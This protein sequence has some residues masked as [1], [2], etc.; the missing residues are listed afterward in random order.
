MFVAAGIRNVP[1]REQDQAASLFHRPTHNPRLSH[2]AIVKPVLEA[3]S[4]TD[5]LQICFHPSSHPRHIISQGFHAP[6]YQPPRQP[7]SIAQAFK[8][9]H[10]KVSGLMEKYSGRVK[11]A[12]RAEVRPSQGREKQKPVRPRRSGDCSE[13]PFEIFHRSDMVEHG[14]N[15]AN[16]TERNNWEESLSEPSHEARQQRM[17]RMGQKSIQTYRDGSE[18]PSQ[19]LTRGSTHSPDVINHYR[20]KPLPQLPSPRQSNDSPVPNLKLDALPSEPR[21]GAAD[22]ELY[23]MPEGRQRLTQQWLDPLDLGASTLDLTV[24]NA[25]SGGASPAASPEPGMWF[26]QR[27][28]PGSNIRTVNGTVARHHSFAQRPKGP[29][30]VL[31]TPNIPERRSSLAHRDAHTMPRIIERHD[32]L[33]QRRREAKNI[34]IFPSD[35][36]DSFVQRGIH[37]LRSMTA[38]PS[39]SKSGVREISTAIPEGHVTQERNSHGGA[40]GGAMMGFARNVSRAIIPTKRAQRE[41]SDMA[42]LDVAPTEMMLPC[43]NCGRIPDSVLLQS[44]CRECRGD[45]GP[46]RRTR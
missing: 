21:V 6:E 5:R 40:N 46:G 10:T 9:V 25:Q 18:R 30:D 36:R 33:V 3:S 1:I 38:S 27:N 28:R 41:D 39:S 31:T 32:S 19:G 29:G 11:T 24:G 14:A 4:W 42:F 44:L 2:K 35:S 20:Y 7:S 12:Y 22:A 43:R 17:A 26:G 16:S 8:R 34:P 13:S 45:R 15:G 23:A 37:R